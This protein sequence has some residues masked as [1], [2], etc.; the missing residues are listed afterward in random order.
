MLVHRLVFRR[1][2]LLWKMMGMTLLCLIVLSPSWP[3]ASAQN[4]SQMQPLWSYTTV[5]RIDTLSVSGDGMYVIVGTDGGF[6]Y[7]FDSGGKQVLNLSGVQR[8]YG[9]QKELYNVGLSYDAGEVL[10]G[11]GFY[12]QT[13]Q[14]ISSFSNNLV[15]PAGYSTSVSPNVTEYSASSDSSVSFLRNGTADGNV[16]WSAPFSHGVLQTRALITP[17]GTSAIVVSSDSN[18]QSLS[19]SNGAVTWETTLGHTV[20]GFASSYKDDLVAVTTSDGL[21]S[22]INGSGVVIRSINLPNLAINVSSGMVIP[23]NVALPWDASYVVVGDDQ[24]TLKFLD[25]NGE[26]ISALSIFS[27]PIAAVG[28]SANG[29]FLAVASGK[30]LDFLGPLTTQTTTSSRTSS[31]TRV[32]T[33]TA[34]VIVVRTSVTTLTTIA[35]NTQTETAVQVGGS[36]ISVTDFLLIASLIVG[37]S[38]IALGAG[39]VLGRRRRT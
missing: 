10:A 18:V 34:V 38:L 30:T 8:T 1:F 14:L 39:I 16:V 27:S 17:G 23:Q 33:I 28:V 12:D 2:K 11:T 26:Q 36:V 32:T 4:T 35:M 3:P 5:N 13:G 24:G 6:A 37:I 25:R 15:G 20:I 31:D 22:Y 21:L 9:K 29:Q 19:A 7:L